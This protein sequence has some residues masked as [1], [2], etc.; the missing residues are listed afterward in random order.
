MDGA[1]W[2]VGKRFGWVKLSNLNKI[3]AQRFFNEIPFSRQL[4]MINIFID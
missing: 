3:I 1:L 2:E 4:M